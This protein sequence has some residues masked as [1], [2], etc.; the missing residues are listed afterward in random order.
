MNLIDKN[1]DTITALCNKKYRV[2]ELY[3]FGS[4]LTDNFND[5]SDVDMLVQFAS[6]ELSDYFDNYMS[7][8][9]ELEVVLN[10]SVDI[11]E[12]QAIRNPV[13]RSIVDRDKKLIYEREGA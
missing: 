8:K 3:L 10:R 5:A 11:V 12:N 2:K 6:V 4:I 1:I 9:D 13:F 7:F